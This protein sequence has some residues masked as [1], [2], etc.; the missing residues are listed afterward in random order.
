M[1][2]LRVAFL[3]WRT[4]PSLLREKFHIFEIPPDCGAPQSEFFVCLCLFLFV[5][6]HLCLSCLSRGCSFVLCCGGSVHS[7]FRFSSEEIVPDVA[8][9]LLY[10]WEEVSTGSPYAAILKSSLQ[11]FW[12]FILM[13][14]I[15]ESDF[16]YDYFINRF[17]F[18]KF[19]GSDK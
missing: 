8:V 17:V 1:Q 4:N 18:F 9:D 14:D 11:P 12:I 5:R 10:L 16:S 7:V 6:S 15:T 19:N 3:M 2:D 13:L